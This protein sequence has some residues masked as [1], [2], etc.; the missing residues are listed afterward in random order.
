[1]FQFLRLISFLS[2]V[3]GS[4]RAVDSANLVTEGWQHRVW[5][6]YPIEKVK[7]DEELPPT[8]KVD[9]VELSAARGEREP[10]ILLLR[11]NIPL[12][13]VTVLTSD[14]RHADGSII[15]AGQL[16]AQRLGY[17]FV[18]EP[19]GTRM[20]QAMPYPVGTGLFPDPLLQNRGDV[21][22]RHNLQFL[23]TVHVPRDARADRYEG[24]V[25]LR[26][27]KESWMAADFI[28]E[29]VVRVIVNVRRF[30]MPE[31]SPLLN[32]S[33]ANLRELP[34][35]Q[36]TPDSI[37]ALQRNFIEHRQTPEPL[38]PS[39]RIKVDAHGGLTVD[40]SAW[41]QAVD[42]LFKNGGTHIF[43]PV[44][45]FHP[46]PALAQGL[47][48]LYHYPAVTGQ[49]WMGVPICAADKTL[50]PEFQRLFGA[51]LKHMHGVLQRRGW[52]D[53][54]FIGT[55]DEPYTYHTG[56]RANDIP[57][58]NYEVIRNF[59]RL[60]RETAP[61]LRTFCTADPADGLTGHID[62]WCLRN[63]DHA[64]AAKERAEKHGEIVTFCD[65]YRTFIDYPA[66]SARSLGWLA[67]HIGARGWLTYET[68]G[69]YRTAWEAPVLV[70]AQFSGATVWGMGQMFYPDPLTGAPLNSLRWEL[71]REGCD[72]F[73]YLWLLREAL[74]AKPDADAQ[75][76]LDT[77]A[78]SI[79]AGGGD[80]ETLTRTHTT[81]ATSSLAAHHL[82]AQIADWL[83]RLGPA[84]D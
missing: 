53:R 75:R 16:S 67:W 17:V 18:D 55:M 42:A 71:M 80:A 51:Y 76:L 57:A 5:S 59:V 30:A 34:D 10:F 77:A 54:A 7:A 82:R 50:T 6:I 69:S 3:T 1:M 60:V 47:Y 72:D 9:T 39:P 19:S 81:N 73:E 26:F 20:K 33:F 24:D 65:N 23:I 15:A 43:V 78:Q 64:A 52:L 14:L 32:T 45:G 29:D 36:R 44:W 40:S 62:H 11:P 83:E 25:R 84:T 66:I 8:P 12:R 46:E 68:F 79:V 13:D 22:P 41:E 4:L 27:R 21:R 31:H 2:L 37:A 63:L 28:A 56:D 70:Y 35:S 58:N 61:G 38:L 74:K 49:K 48:F